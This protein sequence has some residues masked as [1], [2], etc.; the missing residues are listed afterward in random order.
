MKLF[1]THVNNKRSRHS[2]NSTVTRLRDR[3][4]EVR[5]PAGVDLSLLKNVQ[6]GSGAHP[7]S[8]SKGTENSFHASKATGAFREPPIPPFRAEIKRKFNSISTRSTCRHGV[9]R[10]SFTS[11]KNRQ[12]CIHSTLTR[13]CCTMFLFVVYC[14]DRFRL[15]WLAIF[16]ELASLLTCATYASTNVAEIHLIKIVIRIKIINP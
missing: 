14:S 4:S 11:V 9:S 8:Y 15:W 10:D 5:I 12:N 3:R 2:V 16:T 1:V 6:I 13:T 7:A